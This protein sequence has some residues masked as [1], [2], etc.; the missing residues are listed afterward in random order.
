MSSDGAYQP[1]RPHSWRRKFSCAWRGTKCGLR[2][3][4]SFFVH[5]FMAAAVLVAAWVLN[6]SLL[7]FYILL[8]CI[9]GVLTA[10]MFNCALERL[11]KVITSKYDQDVCD[12]LDTSSA[13]VLL[14]SIG[15]AIVGSI[16]FIRRLGVLLDWWSG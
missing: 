16:I 14:A 11:A 1:Q 6:V 3:E 7:E 9:A 4:S 10:E 5:L 12:A 15:A 13:A 8:V 2:G